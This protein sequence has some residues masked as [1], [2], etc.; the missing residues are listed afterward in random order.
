LSRWSRVSG[1]SAIDA[2]SLGATRQ[3]SITEGDARGKPVAF[4][5]WS[6][7]RSATLGPGRARRFPGGTR[8]PTWRIPTP[9]ARMPILISCASSSASDSRILW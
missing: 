4:E 6:D 8:V 5:R 1:T 2:T 3:V 9:F 7:E